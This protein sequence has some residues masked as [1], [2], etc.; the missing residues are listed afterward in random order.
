[1]ASLTEEFLP[2]EHWE[3]LRFGDII[4]LVGG[5]TYMYIGPDEEHPDIVLI[6]YDGYVI[7]TSVSSKHDGWR[8]LR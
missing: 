3:D 8:V 1:M 7:L 6:R 5:N 4:H 2:V